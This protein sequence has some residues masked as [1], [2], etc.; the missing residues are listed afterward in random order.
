ML[1]PSPKWVSHSL[2][3]KVEDSPFWACEACTTG[4]IFKVLFIHHLIFDL[5]ELVRAWLYKDPKVSVLQAN[6][7]LFQESAGHG[8]RGLEVQYWMW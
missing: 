2:W 3:F 5:D 4:E 6:V 7:K 1:P 8:I